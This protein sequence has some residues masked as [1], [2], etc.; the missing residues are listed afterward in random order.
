MSHFIS[1][2]VGLKGK[3]PAGSTSDDALDVSL[4]SSISIE[5]SQEAGTARTAIRLVSLALAVF[6]VWA[7]FAP[8]TEIATGTGEIVPNGFV[9][10]IQHLEGGIVAELF[11]REGDR[12]V[13]GKP[14]LRMDD[15]ASKAELAK[16]KSRADGIRLEIARRSSKTAVEP[17]SV[18]E[19]SLRLSAIAESQ[20]AAALA[21]D[22][23]HAA[24]IEVALA[25]VE[26]RKAE[27]FSLSQREQKMLE[28]LRIIE[29]TLVDFEKAFTAGAVSRSERD[30]IA[31]EKIQM[32]S[33][34][35]TVTGQRAAA[36]AGL[37]Q[38]Q[39]RVDELRA[40]FRQTAETAIAEL[41]IEAA[42]T[43]E[44][45]R[46][47]EDRLDRTLI[48]APETGRIF[49]L[50]ASNRGQVISPGEQ[51]AQIIPEGQA[52][53]AEVKIPADQIGFISP[54]MD[55]SVK[56][57]TFDYTRFGSIPAKVDSI[58]ASSLKHSEEDPPFFNVRLELDKESIAN[59]AQDRPIQS[60]M[61]VAADIKL[62][63]KTV[64]N[65]LLKPLRSLTDRA[66]SQR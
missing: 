63:K 26:T 17:V 42:S 2:F 16:A 24:Q 45:V 50:A 54:G 60:G 9:Q 20:Q 56:I 4:A 41:E 28:E 11:V 27:L 65:F 40:G 44:L 46:Q 1:Q 14:I 38:S 39:A 29:R 3:S 58:S 52:I 37:S 8:V 18:F 32:E 33:S 51:I 62:G 30:K 47:L 59:S 43:E 36:E 57:L 13:Q 25:E 48:V 35:L 19:A 31:R 12:V 10:T 7:S 53:Y 64:M 23:L 15:L 6:L 21:E 22:T 61:S 55:A 66:M 49:D 34:I 5:E